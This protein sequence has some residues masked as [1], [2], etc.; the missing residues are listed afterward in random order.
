MQCISTAT[1]FAASG[2]HL[3]LHM[4]PTNKRGLHKGNILAC[5][6]LIIIRDK[7]LQVVAKGVK[8]ILLLDRTTYQ[9]VKG[10]SHKNSGVQIESSMTAVECKN[11]SGPWLAPLS[12]VTPYFDVAKVP[13]NILFLMMYHVVLNFG[14]TK[15]SWINWPSTK[16]SRNNFIDQQF[17]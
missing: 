13:S 4:K 16:S 7:A 9:K 6:F 5:I 2:S 17:R 1:C 3:Y 14:G 11:D 10:H 15:I 8:Y 12:S